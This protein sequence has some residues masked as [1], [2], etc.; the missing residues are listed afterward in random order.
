MEARKLRYIA[1]KSARWDG[2]S[3]LVTNSRRCLHVVIEA[4]AAWLSAR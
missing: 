3:Q 4:E 1:S 2:F